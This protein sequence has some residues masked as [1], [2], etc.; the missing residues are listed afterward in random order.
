[1][2]VMNLF[3]GEGCLRMSDYLHIVHVLQEYVHARDHSRPYSRLL[4]P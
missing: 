3:K 4:R 2:K 1:M